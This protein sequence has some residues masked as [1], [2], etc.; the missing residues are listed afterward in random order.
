MLPPPAPLLER[1]PPPSKGWRSGDLVDLHGPWELLGDNWDSEGLLGDN[2]AVCK[3]QS[4]EGRELGIWDSGGEE[5][6]SPSPSQQGW[7]GVLGLDVASQNGAGAARRASALVA[8][9]DLREGTGCVGPPVYNPVTVPTH[10]GCAGLFL[11]FYICVLPF[12]ARKGR[13][14]HVNKC[15]YKVLFGVLIYKGR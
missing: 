12:V 6:L 9:E 14:S 1:P 8:H 13:G 3:S 11:P 4:G 2:V 5:Q 7:L 15:I 10:L